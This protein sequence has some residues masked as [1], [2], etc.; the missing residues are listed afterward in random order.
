MTC[1][2]MNLSHSAQLQKNNEV[3][4]VLP[5]SDKPCLWLQ[6]V[7]THPLTLPGLVIKIITY[8]LGLC[9]FHLFNFIFYYAYF[10]HIL[11]CVANTIT[12]AYSPNHQLSW[13]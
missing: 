12:N 11:K 3:S 5:H 1:L 9:A 4:A 2:A 13:T 8:L 10:K 7:E 6:W